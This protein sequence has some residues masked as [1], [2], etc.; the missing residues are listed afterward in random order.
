V[1]DPLKTG[2]IDERYGGFLV[3]LDEQWRPTGPHHKS[4]E[5]TARTTAAFARLHH[6]FPD[7]GLD[8]LAARGC[9]Y[10]QEVMWDSHN[11]GFFSSV[12]RSGEPRHLGLKHPHAHTYALMALAYASPLLPD[13]EAE[14]WIRMTLSWMDDVAWDASAGGYW[15]S[16]TND[17]IRYE[18]GDQ[19]PTDDGRDPLGTANG[20]KE[21]NTLSDSVEMHI[22][23]LKTNSPSASPD[24]L[25]WLCDL[26]TR[27]MRPNGTLP[28]LYDRNWGLS[29]DVVRVGY[30]FQMARHLLEAA[31][32]LEGDTQR[33]VHAA[34]RM[35]EAAFEGAQHPSGGLVFAMAEDGRR[36]PNDGGPS[37]ARQWWVQ[38]EAVHALHLFAGRSS[39]ELAPRQTFAAQRNRQWDYVF[40]YFL[41]AHHGGV[42]EF[43]L[44]PPRPLWQSVIDR[45]SGH[46]RTAAPKTSGWKDPWH[47]VG[48]LL[49]LSDPT[50]AAP[51]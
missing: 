4:L 35:T 43:P 46:G 13:G 50:T 9:R 21:V 51:D 30:H 29:A 12:T 23:L 22:V 33:Y 42:R 10:L 24:R 28:Y 44:Q 34:R 26:V 40:D 32:A 48:C 5:H 8:A 16:Y 19:L 15:G 45:L 38:L 41:D 36:W 3:D 31:D 2:C 39:L 49:A 14:D 1:I 17:N 25:R 11:S 6:R 37:D 18:T 7:E 20:Y 47:E 27:L